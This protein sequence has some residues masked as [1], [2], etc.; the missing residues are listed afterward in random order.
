MESAVRSYM[1]QLSPQLLNR[2]EELELADQIR[3]G[4]EEADKAF[5]KLV[6]KN[7]KLVVKIAHDF[8]GMGLPLTDLISNGNLGLMKAAEKFDAAKARSN[9]NKFSTYAVWWIK[10]NIRD[11]LSQNGSSGSILVPAAMRTR[12]RQ[13]MQFAEQISEQQDAEPTIQQ[14]CEATKKSER[15]IRLLLAV[16]NLKTVS[17]EAASEN[18]HDFAVSMPENRVEHGE[19]I[20]HLRKCFKKL[21]E[22]HALVLLLRFGLDGR[23]PL[24]LNAIGDILQLSTERVRQIEKQALEELTRIYRR[25]E[26]GD[27]AKHY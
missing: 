22:R 24:T 12:A 17:L 14:L 11:A 10:R 15:Q 8:K 3:N 1:S 6:E 13:V 18:G 4:G 5:Q 19:S 27:A 2:E 23:E 7:L 20:R 21:T 25:E 26:L 16:D 9:G